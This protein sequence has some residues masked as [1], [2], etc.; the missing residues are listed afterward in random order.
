M[1]AEG[2][3]DK[4]ASDMEV[5]NETEPSTQ[6]KKGTHWHS[7]TLAEHLWKPNTE[8][9]H[10]EVVHGVFQQGQQQIISTSTDFYRCGTQAHVHCWWKCIA[11]GGD[12]VEKVFCSWGFALKKIVLLCFLYLLQ[13]VWKLIEDITFGII[14]VT[15]IHTHAHSHI[16]TLVK[17]V[18]LKYLTKLNKKIF[19]F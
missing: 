17:D 18:L 16:S 13:F 2:Q 6:G 14:Y 19:S 15:Q 4:M 7:L 11:N 10:S 8:H 3:S 5:C 9:Q 1:V 12:H